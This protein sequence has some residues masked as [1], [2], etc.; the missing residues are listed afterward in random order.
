MDDAAQ[1]A[2]GC[3]QAQRVHHASHTLASVDGQGGDQEGETGRAAAVYAR[4]EGHSARMAVPCCF[5]SQPEA[6]ASP[7]KTVV[8][9]CS[10]RTRPDGKRGE[11]AGR[12]RLNGDETGRSYRAL[13]VG[14]VKAARADT[15]LRC[16]SFLLAATG[17]LWRRRDARVLSSVS[18]GG[19]EW[20]CRR[21]G[22]GGR[23]TG[24]ANLRRGKS[25]RH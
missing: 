9:G 25:A 15:L 24:D 14:V 2:L 7:L 16:S 1:P 11:R 20:L 4:N 3:S 10:G 13:L 18:R 12:R 8:T 6:G 22:S 19:C 17:R 5:K 23:R 21:C